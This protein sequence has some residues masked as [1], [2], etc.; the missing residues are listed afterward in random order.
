M[1]REFRCVGRVWGTDSLEAQDEDIMDIQSFNPGTYP[2]D[3]LRG[4]RLTK[5]IWIDAAATQGGGGQGGASGSHGPLTITSYYV[6]PTK[7]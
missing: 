7:L 6:L 5:G 2:S 1:K 3:H 4:P